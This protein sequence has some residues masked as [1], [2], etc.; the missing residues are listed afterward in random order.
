MDN[1]PPELP[2]ADMDKIRQHLSEQMG[3]P[4]SSMDNILRAG[5]ISATDNIAKLQHAIN[6]MDY[7][8]IHRAAHALKGSV[9]TIGLS[10]IQKAALEMERNAREGNTG[11]NYKEKLQSLK[12]ALAPLTEQST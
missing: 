1:T 7:D 2:K 3:I 12:K 11:Y 4:E 6:D 10:D 9:G 8:A 5:V